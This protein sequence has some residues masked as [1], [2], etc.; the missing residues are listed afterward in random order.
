MLLHSIQPAYYF[1][2]RAILRS[3]VDRFAEHLQ[4]G[5]PQPDI[6]YGIRIVQGALDYYALSIDRRTTPDLAGNYREVTRRLRTPDEAVANDRLWGRW[7][8]AIRRDFLGLCHRRLADLFPS[9]DTGK[10]QRELQTS[11]AVF[12]EA[13]EELS[14]VSETERG[15]AWKLWHGYLYRNLARTYFD[16][17][18]NGPGRE[19]AGQAGMYMRAAADELQAY[20]SSRSLGQQLAFEEALRELDPAVHSETPQSTGGE[21]LDNAVEMLIDAQPR[22]EHTVLWWKLCDYAQTAAKNVQR[23]DIVDKLNELRRPFEK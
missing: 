12:Q 8:E 22:K 9:D 2:D 11:A 20:P 23:Q 15:T 1:E 17:G 21:A 14:L 5:L 16:L 19:A 6:N 10:R 7:A 4:K 13:L 18:E 3:L